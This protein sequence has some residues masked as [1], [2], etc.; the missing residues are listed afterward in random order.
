MGGGGERNM[1]LRNIY[2][3][4]PTRS[5]PGDQTC[6]LDMWCEWESNLPCFG[7]QANAPFN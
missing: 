3:L 1:N 6:N 5:L 2:L 4:S 7:I